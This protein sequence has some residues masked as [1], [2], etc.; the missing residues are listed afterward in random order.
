TYGLSWPWELALQPHSPCVHTQQ[1][2]RNNPVVSR[3][4]RFI[5]IWRAEGWQ[6][7]ERHDPTR[8]AAIELN[9]GPTTL[10]KRKILAIANCTDREIADRLGLDPLVVETWVCVFFDVRKT[11]KTSWPYHRVIGREK[12]HGDEVF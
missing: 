10:R 7:A 2:R 9:D 1:R 3:V 5:A 12:F 8:A 11:L 6:A 4:V